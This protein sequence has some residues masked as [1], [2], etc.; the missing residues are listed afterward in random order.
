MVRVQTNPGARS[1]MSHA[2]GLLAV[3]C[4]TWRRLPEGSRMRGTYLLALFGAIGVSL[5]VVGKVGAQAPEPQDGWLRSLVVHGFYRASLRGKK[6]PWGA[7]FL[8]DLR[9]YPF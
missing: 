3:L 7:G 1:R 2:L 6:N 9:G 5:F 8:S 4:F